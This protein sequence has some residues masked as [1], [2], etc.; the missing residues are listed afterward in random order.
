MKLTI[1][2]N[3]LIFPVGTASTP[4]E[5]IFSNG[6][7]V[8]YNIVIKLDN[9]APDFYAY[10]DV[11]RFKGQIL[12][13]SVEP[14]MEIRF[15]ESD[16][17]DIDN[18]YTE[19]NRPQIHFTAK[20]GWLNDPNGLIYTN[21]IYHMFFQHNPGDVHWRKSKHWGHA[22]SDDL[23]H[24]KEEN[25]ALFPDERG[26][27]FS[28][29]A[30]LDEKNIL[31]KNN[32][33]KKAAVLF[34]TTTAP[35]SQN[36]S[37]SADDFKT[38]HHYE[39]NPII[40]FID[41]RNRDPKVVF[42]DELDCYI[43]LLYIT[44][45][46]YYLFTSDNLTDWALLQSINMLGERECPDIF[47]ISDSDGN[48]RWII[49]G[50]SDKYLV[51]KFEDGKFVP[52]Q[53]VMSLHYGS[54]AYAGQSFSNLPGGRVVRVV[55]NRWKT[56]PCSFSGQMGIPMELSLVK[57]NGIYYI[58]ANPVVE[59][60]TLYKDKKYL[61][62]VTI[63]SERNF[64]I[65]LDDS[66]Y[67]FRMKG[68]YTDVGNMTICVFG[69]N[70]DVNFFKNELR[71]GDCTAPVSITKKDFDFTVIVDRCSMEIFTDDGKAYMS[72][73]TDYASMDRNIPYFTL[74]SDSMQNI[75]E[76]EIISLKSIWS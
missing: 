34:Y 63:S 35:Y 45:N 51:G 7:D 8:V 11:A 36:M 46:L 24:W 1:K 30:I 54:C 72:C 16:T 43:M 62:N 29:S 61:E 27:M 23:I 12:E 44:E 31:G 3:Y 66:P 47:P 56:K 57:F 69:R 68:K 4:K 15:R 75:K 6:T 55:W 58:E 22:V 67:L 13:L 18:L 5:L 20:N 52:E 60:E 39:G 14:E 40:P 32:G 26:A 9:Y 42:C 38:I 53:D 48:R 25:I 17:I 76:I 70:I 71:L 65:K 21:G 74:A 41:D 50:A 49:M 73:L 2:S 64:K 33:D 10:I 59:L 28:G 37:Y 19:P